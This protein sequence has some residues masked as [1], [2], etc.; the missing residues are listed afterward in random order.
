M[1]GAKLASTTIQTCVL[2][3]A[4]TVVACGGASSPAA[5]STPTVPQ[6]G[7]VYSGPTFDASTSPP[8]ERLTWTITT[9]RA[10][11]PTTFRSCIGTLT[12][13]QSVTS[14]IGSFSEGDTCAPVTG[15]VAA[16]VVGTDG[17]VTFSLVGPT[18]DPLAW[19]SHSQCT[20]VVPGT[21]GFTG[22]VTDNLLD[23]SFAHEA[24]VQCAEGFLTVNVRV[25]GVR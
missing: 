6:I 20:P 5:P 14:F 7:G 23:A 11:N 15:Q 3:T 4:A 1:Q 16:G 13:L 8:L 18:D 25:R 10:G 17:K 22:T 9:T 21:M 19:T 2:L 12:I 24:I